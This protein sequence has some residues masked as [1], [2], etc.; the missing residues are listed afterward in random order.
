MSMW[1]TG[2]KCGCSEKIHQ[3]PLYPSRNFLFSLSR[4]EHSLCGCFLCPIPTVRLCLY[5]LLPFSETEVILP[6][7]E[8]EVR[9]KVY[10]HSQ[11]V[12]W[13]S[14][15]E[16]HCLSDPVS[17]LIPLSDLLP[18]EEQGT[19]MEEELGYHPAIQW[20]QDFNQAKIQL[21]CGLG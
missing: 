20:L 21:D 18:N 10:P 16:E 17:L 3:H 5:R 12:S 15:E 19:Q 14:S 13:K 1:L 6:L 8:G 7:E 9:L 4:C 2:A 11:E